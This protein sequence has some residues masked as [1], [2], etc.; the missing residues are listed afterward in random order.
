MNNITKL[1]I[2]HTHFLRLLTSRHTVIRH[3]TIKEK[4]LT[5]L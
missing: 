5:V 3:Q 2:L 4:E 1:A